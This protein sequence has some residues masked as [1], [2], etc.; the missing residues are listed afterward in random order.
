MPWSSTRP[1]DRPALPDQ[2]FASQSVERSRACLIRLAFGYRASQAL[3]STAKSSACCSVSTL[4]PRA[5]HLDQPSLLS[6]MGSR[7]AEPPQRNAPTARSAAAATAAHARPERDQSLFALKLKGI[8]GMTATA[9]P[10]SCRPQR[11]AGGWRG[12]GERRARRGRSHP[13]STRGLGG[14]GTSTAGS[15]SSCSP[16]RRTSRPA[17]RWRSKTFSSTT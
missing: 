5:G 6:Q 15:R 16:R 10:R 12:S 9:W 3:P 13:G 14:P 8:T 4:W 7:G 11:R 1:R 17:G 2:T